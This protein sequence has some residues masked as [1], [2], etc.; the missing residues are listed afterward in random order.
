M[1]IFDVAYKILV[2]TLSSSLVVAKDSNGFFFVLIN[3]V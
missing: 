2:E 1:G 3:A